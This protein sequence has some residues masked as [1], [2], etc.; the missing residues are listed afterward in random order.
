MDMNMLL[1]VDVMVGTLSL[2]LLSLLLLLLLVIDNDDRERGDGIQSDMV[3]VLAAL[4]GLA[5]AYELS[6]RWW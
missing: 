6:A 2:L 4:L 3:T 5:I 1:F